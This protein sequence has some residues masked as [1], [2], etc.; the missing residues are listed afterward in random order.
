[1]NKGPRS[2]AALGMTNVRTLGHFRGKDALG[3]PLVGEDDRLDAGNL[4]ALAAAQ[5]LAGHH[6]VFAQHVGAGFG[7]AGA[8]AFVGAAGKLVLLGA[9]Q[10]GHFIFG[11]LMTVGTVQRGWFLFLTFVKEIALF[12]RH[13]FPAL[14]LGW[15][16]DEQSRPV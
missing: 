6:V 7:E 11:R 16:S 14:G 15:Y 8:V 5:V 3:E 9:Y 1:R 12:H 10:P 13:R 2:L 4:E